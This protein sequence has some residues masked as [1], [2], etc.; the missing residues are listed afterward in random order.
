MEL[1]NPRAVYLDTN[2]IIQSIESDGE[3]LVFLIE[4]ATED[5]LQLYTSE[6][7]LAEVLVGPLKDG[8]DQLV[9]QYEDLLTSDEVLEVVPIDRLLLRRSAEIRATFGNKGYDSIHVATAER[10]G[11]K[12]FVSSDRRLRL[13]PGLRKLQSDHLIDFE[14]WS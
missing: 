8:N 4:K 3:A 2:F 14:N 10:C 9:A 11:C 13:P 5:L 12:L 1:G 6:L 7:T